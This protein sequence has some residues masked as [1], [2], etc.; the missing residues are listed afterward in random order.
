LN[1]LVA[2]VEV[3]RNRHVIN[4]FVGLVKGNLETIRDGGGVDTL[5]K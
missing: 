2:V 3:D 4:D 1:Q 5:G